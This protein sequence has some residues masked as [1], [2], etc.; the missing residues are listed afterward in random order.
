ML[1]VLLI[2]AVVGILTWTTWKYSEEGCRVSNTRVTGWVTGTIGTIIIVA[3]I[4]GSY[5]SY[6]DIRAQYD[7]VINQ[8]KGAVTM[9][10]DY[11][12]LDMEKAT[13]TDFRYQ[14]YQE[15]IAKVI[16]DLRKEIITY[17]KTL[18]QKGIMD[19]NPVFSWLIVAPDKD[20]KI[21]NIVE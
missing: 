5:S 4:S 15:N 18:I 17:N 16:I 14:G 13:F 19:K 20:M 7:A 11:A 3:V 6:L 12:S 9:Y 2:V 8:Y 1:L 21:I 10:S